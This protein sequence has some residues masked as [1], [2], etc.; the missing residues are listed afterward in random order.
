VITVSRKRP[1]IS[2]SEQVRRSCSAPPACTRLTELFAESLLFGSCGVEVGFGSL[3]ADAEGGPC[4]FECGDA[5]VC[6]GPV[7]VALAAEVGSD[8]SD[9]LGGLGLGAVGALLG[10]SVGLLRPCASLTAS[11]ESAAS[12]M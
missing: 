12:A 7:L 2:Q 9:F 8:E 1:V 6:G 4:F 3:G 10:G 5:G 11:K